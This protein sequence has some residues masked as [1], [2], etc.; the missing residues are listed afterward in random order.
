MAT[1][2]WLLVPTAFLALRSWLIVIALPTILWRFWAENPSYWGTHYHYS[3]VLIPITYI[4]ALNGVHAILKSRQP[5]GGRIATAYAAILL[6]GALFM[7]V[8]MPLGRLWHAETW[9]PTFTRSEM[10]V[11]DRVPD[12]ATVASENRLAAQL[13]NRAEV[14][15]WPSFPSASLRPEWVVVVDPPEEGI[16]PKLQQLEALAG[17]RSAGYDLVV[18]EGRVALWRTTAPRSSIGPN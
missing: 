5:F 14:Y 4:A 7:I 17:L 15:L 10:A 16:S 13:T 11:L 3:V 8:E 18:R 12:D 9:Q 6:T 2:L 1:L